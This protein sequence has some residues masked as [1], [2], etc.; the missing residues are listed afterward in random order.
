MNQIK[1]SYKDTALVSNKELTKVSKRLLENIKTLNKISNSK[2]Y[3]DHQ[4]SINLPN[5]KKILGEVKKVVKKKL[6][7]NPSYLVVI[8]I[9][10]SNLGTI[11]IQEAVLGKLYNQLN[12]KI[13]ILYAD[14][15]DSDSIAAIKKIVKNKKSIINVISKSGT[16]T[17]T[18]ENFKALLPLVKNKNQVVITTDKNSKL[19]HRAKNEGFDILEIPRKVGGRYSVFSAVGLFPLAMLGVNIDKLLSG[20]TDMKKRC[21]NTNINSNPA[22][23]LSALSYSQ[24]NKGKIIQDM[25]LFSNDLESIGK[26]N[27]QLVAESIGKRKDAGITPTVSIGSTDLHSIAQLYLAGP[28]DKFTEFIS[29]DKTNTPSKKLDTIMDAILKGTKAALKKRKLPF[30]HITLP[31]KSEHSIGQLLQ[32]KMIET[33]FLGHLLNINPFDQPAVEA[34]KEETRRILKKG[35]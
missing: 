30:T 6:A 8:G 22:A 28:R 1:F 3:E 11:A 16:T 24:H 12:P 32:L 7:I 34:Y 26:W 17:E 23:I 9:G 33:I 15:V 25:F 27:R 13:K 31:N 10:G 20:A 19:W 18:I 21:L 35:K 2:T 5:D 29:I 14:T 4:S